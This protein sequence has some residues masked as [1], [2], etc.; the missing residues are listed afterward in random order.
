M[1]DVKRPEAPQWLK[2]DW[3]AFKEWLGFRSE[4]ELFERDADCQT[5]RPAR[6][7]SRLGCSLQRLDALHLLINERGIMGRVRHSGNSATCVAP[8]AGRRC[9]L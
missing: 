7:S 3:R 6:R 9:R 2:D 5:V 4:S 1:R 8:V